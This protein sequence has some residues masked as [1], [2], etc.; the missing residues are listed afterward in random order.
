MFSEFVTPYLK[1]CVAEFR[2]RGAY[3]IKHTDGNIMPILDDLIE[4]APHALHSLDPM[5]GVDIRLVKERTAGRLALCGNVHC[6]MMQTGTPAQIR[7]SAEYCMTWGKPGGGYVFCTSN[8]VFRGMPLAN[9]DLI[10][11][12][13]RAGRDY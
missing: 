9:Y 3:V 1:R 4:A 8:S 13:W 5:A 2:R 12:V 11:E 10:Q 6:A 7:Q